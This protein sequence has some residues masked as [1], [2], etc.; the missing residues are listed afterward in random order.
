MKIQFNI[1]ILLKMIENVDQETLN[2][3]CDSVDCASK[4]STKLGLIQ[5]IKS[6]Q[7]HCLL[8]PSPFLPHKRTFGHLLHYFLEVS[9]SSQNVTFISEDALRRTFE[10][11]HAENISNEV[12][13][14]DYFKHAD[15]FQRIT[16]PIYIDLLKKVN[17]MVDDVDSKIFREFL[18][19]IMYMR[20]TWKGCVELQDVIAIT[21]FINKRKRGEEDGITS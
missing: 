8:K 6:L 14:T 15:I 7:E 1:I 4:V 21:K 11:F 17:D 9:L 5:I 10:A 12:N 19:E 16:Y 20:S 2:T 3:I 18:G 13:D